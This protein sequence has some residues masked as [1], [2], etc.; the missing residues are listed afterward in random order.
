ME[1]ANRNAIPDKYH[2]N[3]LKICDRGKGV[4]V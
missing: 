2:L 4:G 1:E 3:Y